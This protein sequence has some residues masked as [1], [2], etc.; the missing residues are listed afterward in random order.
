M[1]I[2]SSPVLA[3]FDPAKPTFLKIDWSVEGIG[4]IL[5]QPADDSKSTK[6]TKVLLNSG[7][8][9][10]NLSKDGDRLHIVRFESRACT[11]FECKY[12]S[13][14]GETAT[15]RWTIS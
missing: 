11:D 8:C 10:L 9:T 6:A 15:D 12:H 1:I 14:V 7:E 5:I 2:I 3:K 13:F 4:W